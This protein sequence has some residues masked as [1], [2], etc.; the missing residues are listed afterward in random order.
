M[1]LA[2]SV[3]AIFA[4][5]TPPAVT[6]RTCLPRQQIFRH[7]HVVLGAVVALSCS[8]QPPFVSLH[9]V[10]N[11][12]VPSEIAQAKIILTIVV[13]LFGSFTK[14]FVSL[15]VVLRRPASFAVSAA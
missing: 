5:M 11:H 6:N 9:L 13:I 10:L 15:H 2:A 1:S 3:F 8:Q 7:D 12:T 14:P 4:E